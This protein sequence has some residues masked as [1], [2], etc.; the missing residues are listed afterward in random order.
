MEHGFQ[1]LMIAAAQMLVTGI[2]TVPRFWLATPL[3]HTTNTT[4]DFSPRNPNSSN[5][6]KIGTGAEARFP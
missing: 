3:N 6:L 4:P 2:S 1:L 5:L